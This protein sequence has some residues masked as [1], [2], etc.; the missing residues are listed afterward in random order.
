MVQPIPE[1]PRLPFSEGRWTLVHRFGVWGKAV[2]LEERTAQQSRQLLARYGVVTSASLDNEIG[3]WDWGL[4]Y[5]YLQRLELRGEVRRGYFVQGLAGVQF[6]LPGVVEQLRLARSSA[7]ETEANEAF[8]V[9]NAGDPAN[10]YGPAFEHSPPTA[11]GEPL[12]FPRLPST[13]LVQRRGLP[14][15]LAGDTGANLTL[16]AGAD[17]SAIRQA[18][19]AFCLEWTAR[20]NQSRPLPA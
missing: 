6:A 4:I 20:T 16:M 17:E 10:L 15:L 9:L 14:V 18:I 2:S 7:M 12:T 8:V 19:L 11:A 1:T 3:A 5:Q 13:W